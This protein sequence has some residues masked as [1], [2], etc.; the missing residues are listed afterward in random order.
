MDVSSRMAENE[1]WI[2]D[3]IDVVTGSQKIVQTDFLIR[4]VTEPFG[5]TRTY[6]SIYANKGLLGS[7]WYLNVESWIR[8]EED[9]AAII[10]PDMHLEE[11][12]RTEEEWCN[13]R[14]GDKAFYL[15]ENREGYCL[16]L[17]RERK[18]YFYDSTGRLIRIEDRNGNS[19]W[20]RYVGR[21]L[22]EISFPGGQF[23]KFTYEAGKISSIT[24]VIGRKTV[25]HYDGEFLTR[26]EYPNRG[27][28][29][30][31]YTSEG[32]LKAITDQN[33]HTYIQNEYDSKGRVTRQLLA[34]GQEYTMLYDEG[35]RVNTFLTPSIGKRIEY[36]YN[37]DRLLVKTV[38]TD[39][40]MEERGY[41][42][43]QNLNYLK[44]RRGGEVYRSFGLMGELLEER[45]P[46]GLVT[47][48]TYD[49]KGNLLRE[50]DN[51]GRKWEFCYDHRGNRVLSRAA[52]DEHQWQET[53]Y[54]YDE[55]GRLLSVTDPRGAISRASYAQEGM[56][57]V[58]FL[59]AE[60]Y[61]WK[62]QYDR[63]G[64]CICVKG[65]EGCLEYAYNEMDKPVLVTDALG[66]TVCYVYDGQGNLIKRVAPN[67]YNHK[68]GNGAGTQYLY[69]A[70]DKLICRIDPLGNAY[71]TPRDPEGNIVKEIHP[72]SYNA[73]K[74]EGEGIGYTYD[75]D[76]RLIKIHY[77][78]GGTERRQYDAAGNLVKKI[79][80]EQY[81]ER[82]D[83]GPGY[84]CIYDEVNRL[85]QI[86]D[87]EGRV[88]RRYVYDLCGNILKE[89]D[90]ADCVSAETDEERIGTLYTYNARGWL[91]G[92]REPVEEG[93]GVAGYRL[94]EYAYDQA[95]NLTGE[96]RYLE[97]Q[98]KDSKKG[99]VHSLYFTYDQDN[100]CTSVKDSTG[101]VIEYRYNSRNQCIRE[102]RKITEELF[103]LYRYVYDEGGRLISVLSAVQ[104]PAGIKNGGKT[105]YTYDPSG[106][107]I[108]IQLPEGGEIRREYDGADRLIAE[109]HREKK[110]GIKNRVRFLYDK[111]GNLVEI[112]EQQG[113]K[114][115]IKY[116]LLNREIKRIQRDGS[117][118]IS[119][120]HLNGQLSWRTQTSQYQEAGEEGKGCRY[121]YDLQG[122]LVKVVGPDGQI[123][124]ENSYDREGR[125]VERLGGL[126]DGM[127]FTYNLAGECI[128]I[129]TAKGSC[130][131]YQRD[132]R[133]N[134]L[135]AVGDSQNYI[136]YERDAWGRI[137]RIHKADGSQESYAYDY[138]GNLV[139]ATDGEGNTTTYSYDGEGHLLS[140]MDTMGGREE[141]YYD[142]EGRLREKRDRKG[143][144][145]EYAYTLYGALLHR[146]V[147][148][149]EE[150][151]FY[152]YTPEGLLQSACFQ[153]NQG[154]VH[155][156]YTDDSMDRLLEKSADSS[157]LLSFRYDAK[158]NCFWRR[159]AQGKV[160]QY[161]YD[162]CDCLE[163]VRGEGR[164]FSACSCYAKR[165]LKEDEERIA[166][167]FTYAGKR[168]NPFTQE[169]ACGG[170][171]LNLYAYC[172]NNL[173]R[174]TDP[175][176]QEKIASFN[177][178]TVTHCK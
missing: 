26:V 28:I 93:E 94:T 84:C 154:A 98:T 77:P 43:Y 44:D 95:G 25:Y 10:L 128:Y 53:S 101:A 114:T 129:R 177:V 8:V 109:E 119:R 41:D 76:K 176:G 158:G 78:D 74:R 157:P 14:N 120:Y 137:V 5:L 150:G 164:R 59:T 111:A 40:T 9:T 136:A 62:Y 146:R 142:G 168:P 138:A 162:A 115:I 105:R 4:T 131:Q 23:L 33:G 161:R 117:I 36:H 39:G 113:R 45:L 61:E 144:T 151:D 19:I 89:M 60:G 92:K 48:Y 108:R 79:A 63:A 104:T 50:W 152:Q 68:E 58:S 175:I 155:C 174:Y 85:V 145:T 21:T 51:A 90:G 30:Y 27:S 171:G 110:S 126:K 122:R 46:N 135:R 130:Q 70:M 143:M 80:P 116:D 64:R 96:E 75:Q 52:I 1:K 163:E 107:C 57:M 132:A 139:S 24:D 3:P 160:A 100:R 148:G 134:I 11:F 125:L 73:K 91:T 35:R 153:N 69:D 124:E 18:Q 87:P 20:F 32:Y 66:H 47:Y 71:A 156:S 16:H 17:H 81:D 165:R 123:L 67:Q 29:R 83:D 6:Q 54:T 15:E 102:K 140:L 159:D 12:I 103:Q 65:E 141:Y 72:N 167:R 2:N 178:C 13:Q 112:R 170:D 127:K 172:A 149:S 42:N 56:G 49:E 82:T 22:R 55:K 34:N 7:K 38:Y 118:I 97:V 121:G 106:N 133:G 147:R 88:I 31:A 169:G 99:A 173:A 86:S 166:Q 37:R